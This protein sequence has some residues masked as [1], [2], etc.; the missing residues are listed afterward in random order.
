M[1]TPSHR[2]RFL[3]VILDAPRLNYGSDLFDYRWP[4]D[5]AAE[6]GQRVLLPFG[7]QTL[8]G[9]IV[10]ITDTSEVEPSKLRDAIAVLDDVPTLPLDWFT[11]MRFAADYYQRSLGEVALPALPLLLRK[12]KAY[13]PESVQPQEPAR[14]SSRSI[15]QLRKKSMGAAKPDTSTASTQMPILTAEQA[16]AVTEI[17]SALRGSEFQPLLLHGVTGSGKTEVYL[18]A[19]ADVLARGQQAL[20]LV[21]EINLT[22]QLL[23][24]FRGRFPQARLASL[25]SGMPDG[26]RALQWLRVHEGE[27]DILLGTRMAVMVPLPRLGLVVVDEEH[28][29]SFKQQ[30]G[31]R[32]SARDLALVLAQQRRIPI[33]LGSAT[34]SL[35]TW[36]QAER[37]RYK[38]LT[39]SSRAADD[40]AG[41]PQIRMVSLERT[42]LEHGFSETLRN[43][44]QQRLERGE[45]S[46]IF[47]NRRG[48]APVLACGACGW[49]SDCRRCSVHAVFH[50]LDGRLHCHHCGWEARVPKACPDCGNV[51]LA[52]L[53]RGTQRIEETLA[54]WFP[55]ARI[56]RI[57]RDSTRRKGSMQTALSAVH[58]GEV[59]ILVGT[60]MVAKGHDFRHLTLVG[61]V[62]AD[63]AL[64][65]HDFR[66]A[67]RLFANLMQVA[68]R[69]GR[70][71]KPG[72]VLIQTRYPQHPLFAALTAHDFDRFAK[73]QLDERRTAGL[74]PYAYHA[75]LRAEAKTLEAA[76]AFL[77]AAREIAQNLLVACD[78]SSTIDLYD[79]VPMNLVRVANVERAQLLVEARSRPALQ[80][81]LPIWLAALRAI[82]T[83]VQWHVEVDPLEI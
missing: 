68:G 22:P 52:P 1:N 17:R 56:L 77:H 24:I 27:A 55:E 3:R 40:A 64:F 60:Q 72:E 81:L 33:I 25:H 39:L 50:K 9:L 23:E 53:G 57:D 63:S 65:S 35:E 36:A 7:R 34:P 45:Q 11:L 83:R 10:E 67:E 70:A 51:D 54:S 62:D 18:Q 71:H 79:P 80:N 4:D 29:P 44:I 78:Q 59:D 66:A 46:L 43:A 5:R 19:L 38:K 73:S 76:L 6:I 69:A 14:Y 30:E 13:R 8:I 75:V 31:L 12:A 74:P 47:H 26:E 41:L 16:V 37:G 58:A 32:Y 20:V 61:V 42:P 21:P 15:R 48:Y 49:I 82:K 28:D 2:N